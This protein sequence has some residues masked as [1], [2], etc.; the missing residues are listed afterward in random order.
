MTSPSVSKLPVYAALGVPEVWVWDA[1]AGALTVRRLGPD[2][3]YRRV[4]DSGELPGFPFAVAAGLL[5]DPA[6]RDSL[7]LEDAFAGAV[8][9]A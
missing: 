5:T 3:A 9:P 8:R 6:R 1:A 4:A 2:G 7:R